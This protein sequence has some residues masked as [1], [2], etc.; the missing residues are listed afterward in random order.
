MP[1]ARNW[2]YFLNRW[3][4]V[5]STPSHSTPRR[6]NA[7]RRRR[8][9]VAFQNKSARHRDD[10]WVLMKSDVRTSSSSYYVYVYRLTTAIRPRS[11]HDGFFIIIHILFVTLRAPRLVRLVK[12]YNAVLYNTR[13]AIFK[14]FSK[15]KRTHASNA[16]T[17]ANCIIIYVLLP[18]TTTTRLIN[19]FNRRPG[20]V[21]VSVAP[22]G[23]RRLLKI[24]RTATGVCMEETVT[25]LLGRTYTAK[26]FKQCD[27]IW[28]LFGLRPTVSQG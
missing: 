1:L 13:V 9:E 5:I 10:L 8:R 28:P 11:I 21:C 23:S 7:L 22:P 17:T 16:Y 14:R 24:T 25:A 18:L 19:W 27:S 20:G 12:T 4:R 6:R 15:K 3:L 2:F 26:T